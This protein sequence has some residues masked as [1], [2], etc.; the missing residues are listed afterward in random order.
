MNTTAYFDITLDQPLPKEMLP[1]LRLVALGGT[2]AFLLESIFRNAVW[3]HL[4]LPVSRAN[5]E[6]ICQVVRNACK[7]AL[8][9]YNTTLEEVSHSIYASLRHVIAS[10]PTYIPAY[11]D[12]EKHCSYRMRS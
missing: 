8:A 3:D 11:I 2:D 5:E 12:H 1:Y 10:C 9:G 6:V 7:S 4:Q